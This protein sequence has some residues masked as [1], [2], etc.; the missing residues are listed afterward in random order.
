MNDPDMDGEVQISETQGLEGDLGGGAVGDAGWKGEGHRIVCHNDPPAAALLARKHEGPTITPAARADMLEG[1]P[2]TDTTAAQRLFLRQANLYYE[3]T[4][5]ISHRLGR[6]LPI[7]PD[8]VEYFL[9]EG[10]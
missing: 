5:T 4:L 2:D 1:E 6:R 8:P 7:V 9:K 3:A 10:L